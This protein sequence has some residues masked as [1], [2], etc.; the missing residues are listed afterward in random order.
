M[1]SPSTYTANLFPNIILHVGLNFSILLKF[2]PLNLSYGLV[3]LIF[4]EN[5]EIQGYVYH[6]DKIEKAQKNELHDT[7][8]HDNGVTSS[9]PTQEL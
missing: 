4:Q 9:S 7:L 2:Q 8:V 3:S 6:K 5:I 1:Q